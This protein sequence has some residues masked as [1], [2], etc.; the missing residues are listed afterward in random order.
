MTAHWGAEK[1]QQKAI[2]QRRKHAK[3]GEKPD[4]TLRSWRSWRDKISRENP[5]LV[6]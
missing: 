1:E 4:L 2:A 6:I 5:V 3:L